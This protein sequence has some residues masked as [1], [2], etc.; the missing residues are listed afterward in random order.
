VR[1]FAGGGG[2]EV[3]PLSAKYETG[4]VLEQVSS[5][6]EETCLTLP[7]IEQRILY[8]CFHYTPTALLFLCP[9]ETSKV[10]IQH[11]EPGESFKSRIDHSCYLCAS[12]AVLSVSCC[13]QTGV[14]EEVKGNIS[15]PNVIWSESGYRPFSLLRH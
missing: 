13:G 11:S 3:M 10:R 8:R 15:C 9:Y 14:Q 4:W 7:R 2:G 5:F 1:L 6:E 12:G